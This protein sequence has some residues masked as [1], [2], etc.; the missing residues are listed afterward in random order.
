M[1]DRKP[2]KQTPATVSS[3]GPLKKVQAARTSRVAKRVFNIQ[4]PAKGPLLIMHMRS[5]AESGQHMA[6]IYN[7]S[8]PVRQHTLAGLSSPEVR[9][10]RKM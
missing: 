7:T 9:S 5:W 6:C 3:G 8:L 2:H 10:E 4:Q 1:A